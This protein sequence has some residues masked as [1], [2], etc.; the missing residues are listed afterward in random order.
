MTLPTQI[1]ARL[2]ELGVRPEEVEE[3][4]IR[5]SGPGGQKINKTSSSVWL[6]HRPTGIEVR[7][8][9]ERSQS[10]NRRLAWEELVGRLV[11]RVRKASDAVVA[12]RESERRRNRQKSRGQKRIMVES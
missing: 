10:A 6:R 4:F 1:A 5:G 3:R 9:R 2:A 11:A 7:C 12:A 8:Q